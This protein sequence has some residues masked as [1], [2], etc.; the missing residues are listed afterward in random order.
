MREWFLHPSMNLL[1]LDESEM[2]G[3]VAEFGWPAYRTGTDSSLALSAAS[4]IHQQHDGSEPRGP[5]E[6]GSGRANIARTSHCLVFRSADDT[7]KLVLKL[8]DGLEVEAVLIPDDEPA[9]A[10]CPPRLAVRWTAD[11]VSPARWA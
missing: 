3:L 6:T 4:T 10:V 5:G 2:A 7:R 9:D 1:Y 11:S 8:E